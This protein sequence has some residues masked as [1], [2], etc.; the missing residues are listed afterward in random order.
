MRCK[1]TG[2]GSCIWDG[3]K[4]PLWANFPWIKQHLWAIT[5]KVFFA[6]YMNRIPVIHTP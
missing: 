1:K 4:R 5:L 2:E 6:N 3:V